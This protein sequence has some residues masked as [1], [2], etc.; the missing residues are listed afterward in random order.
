LVNVI[1]IY[2]NLDYNYNNKYKGGIIAYFMSMIGFGYGYKSL[3]RA[4]DELNSGVYYKDTERNESE[5]KKLTTRELL[6]LKRK[7]LTGIINSSDR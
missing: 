2:N 3:Q 7:N 1:L 6:D 4:L 5:E